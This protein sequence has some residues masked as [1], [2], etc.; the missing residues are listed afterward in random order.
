M[1]GLAPTNFI[2]AVNGVPTLDLESFIRET[3]KI[4]DNTYFRLKVRTF[5]NVNWVATLKANYSYFPTV[6]FAKDDSVREGWRRVQYEDG[7]AK[8][9]VGEASGHEEV[10]AGEDGMEE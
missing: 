7:V 8:K 10:E 3:K 5:D 2:M 6:E 4:P 9:G 1:Y